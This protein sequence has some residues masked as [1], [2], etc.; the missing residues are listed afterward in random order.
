MNPLYIKAFHIVFLVTWFAGL[1]YI[2][3]LFIYHV[4][5]GK[6]SPS[7]KEILQN[8]LIIM[9]ERLW[10]IIT[11]PGMILTVLSGSFLLYLQSWMLSSPWLHIKLTLVLLLIVYHFSIGRILKNL[12]KGIVEYKSQKLRLF[13]EL[14][15]V[16]LFAIVFLAVLKSTMSLLVALG[17][18]LALM[19]ILM[20]GVKF[21]KK[22]RE[23]K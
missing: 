19:V 16:F 20:V 17:G 11:W 21:Y 3:R 1:F 9:A 22:A 2:V 18:L 14:P 7:E 12:R 10:Y 8:Q 23:S 4:E 13:N 15:T 6:K 5:A